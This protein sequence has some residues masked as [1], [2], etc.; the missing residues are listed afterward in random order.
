M[1]LREVDKLFAHGIPIYIQNENEFY[2]QRM[3][4][5]SMYATLSER[6]AALVNAIQERG[7]VYRDD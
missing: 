6:R 1:I 7:S 2:R 4:A 3:R 5:Y